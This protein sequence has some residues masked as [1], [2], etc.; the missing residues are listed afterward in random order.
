MPNPEN[1]RQ[2]RRQKERSGEEATGSMRDLLRNDRPLEKVIIYNGNKYVFTYK[3][4]PWGSYLKFIESAWREI[5][6]VSSFDIGQ[7]Y[8]DM[9]LDSLIS[10]PGD[11]NPTRSIL[12]QLHPEVFFQLQTIIPKPSFGGEVDESKKELTQQLEEE[13]LQETEE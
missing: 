10:F 9:L 8:E 4:V 3:N 7:Y 5:N 2:V 1:S 12:R 13:E 11:G 6:G